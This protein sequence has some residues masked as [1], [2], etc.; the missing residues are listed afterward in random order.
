[1]IICDKCKKKTDF[2]SRTVLKGEVCKVWACQ[3]CMKKYHPDMYEDQ[4]V[5]K[6]IVEIINSYHEKQ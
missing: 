2:V 1:M 5:S 4:P 6:E 3:E